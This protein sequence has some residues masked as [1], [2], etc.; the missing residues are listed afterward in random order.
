VCLKLA[1]DP[2]HRWRA[3][4]GIELIHKEPT[5]EELERIWK[6]WQLMSPEQKEISDKKS[7][8]IFGVSN[9]THYEQLT[10]NSSLWRE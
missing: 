9:K 10:N 5:R 3:E 1:S 6:N 2:V 8:E 7:L 4:S